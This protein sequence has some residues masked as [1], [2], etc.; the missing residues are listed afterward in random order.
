MD[1]L[2]TSVIAATTGLVALAGLGAIVSS[3]HFDY[4]GADDAS[5]EQYLNA[6]ATG[7]SAGFNLSAGGRATITDI[8]ANARED[9]LTLSIVLRD[10][11]LDGPDDT[12]R[13]QERDWLSEQS[14]KLAAGKRMMIDGIK[15]RVNAYRPSGASLAEIDV[16]SSSC[17][18]F[19][20]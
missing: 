2:L 15:M 8:A 11:K 7:F 17:E 10:R 14:C 16:D 3:D 18:P 9:A 20:N 13:I 1:K 12:F 5:K 6:V 4:A 19:L